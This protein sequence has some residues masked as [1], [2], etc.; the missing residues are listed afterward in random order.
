MVINTISFLVYDFIELRP[1]VH[2]PNLE[3]L[4]QIIKEICSGHISLELRSMSSPQ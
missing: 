4:P 1:G 3:L 2:I